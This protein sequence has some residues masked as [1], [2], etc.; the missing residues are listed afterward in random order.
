MLHTKT[1]PKLLCLTA[2]LVA[3]AAT[4]AQTPS[5][6]QPALQTSSSPVF[7]IQGFE[8]TGE[9]PLSQ[10]ESTQLLAPYLRADATL[11]TLQQATAALEKALGARGF[12]LHRVVLPPQEVGARVTLN[13]VK[14][15]IGKITIEG[16]K[17]F[18]QANIRASLPEL[19]EGQTP[20]F[21]RLA[22]QT[23]MANESQGKQV[24]VGL[25]ESDEADKI[26]VHVV[27]KE[28]KPWNLSASLSN[29]G[30]QA[31][32]TDRLSLV[33]SHSNVFDLDHQFS[34]AYT[35]SVQHTDAVKQLGANYRIP[36]YSAGGTLGLA[37]THSDVAGNFGSF[38][39]T[40]AG[41]TAG[42]SYSQQ[43]APRGGRRAS[44]SFGLDDKRFDPTKINDVPVPGQEPRGARPL[45]LGYNAKIESDT[46]VWG[47]DAELA[48]NVPGG[49]GNDLASYQS[50]DARIATVHWKALRAGANTL[51]SF[52]GW[53][54]SAKAQLQYSPHALISGE[55]FGLGGATSVRGT[56]ERPLSGDSGVLGSFE[57]STPELQPGLRALG[58][59]D[60]GWL[61]NHNTA[62]SSKPPSD[63][64]ASAGL[65]L[66]YA[67]GAW[68]LSGEWGRIVNGSVM[69]QTPGSSIPKTGDQKVHLNLSLRL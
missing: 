19:K 49:K 4:L 50:E 26:D 44:I 7:A 3:S 9:N 15:V 62:G 53:L 61:A 66:R 59:V 40:G 18:S 65:G 36:M 31:T 17:R 56:D 58:F 12:A 24:Q 48:L 38:S 13:I 45:S 23:A 6:P 64:L 35:T 30:T 55:Q 68:A 1:P 37:Y 42:L 57:L 33:G 29:T 28:A 34:G 25:K 8:I 32:G 10:E 2:L 14:F 67:S 60:A 43:L 46:A 51:S 11:E 63:H 54:Y 47:Y 27:V 21:A 22:V 41:Q 69:A 39:S 16:T 52:A 20:N 5:T